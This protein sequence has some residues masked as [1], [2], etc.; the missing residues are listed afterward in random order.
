VYEIDIALLDHP[1][2]H[3]IIFHLAMYPGVVQTA[4]MYS[5]PSAI[6]TWAFKLSHLIGSAWET[7]KVS[8]AEEET[9]KARLFFYVCARDVLASAMRMLS[10]TPIDRM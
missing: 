2:I 5:E 8:G 7:V 1:K 3:E 4:L 10:L 6:V 9:A